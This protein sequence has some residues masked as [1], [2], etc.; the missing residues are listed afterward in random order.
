MSESTMATAGSTRGMNRKRI[1]LFAAT[2]MALLAIVVGP[3]LPA[4]AATQQ[5]KSYSC[6][7]NGSPNVSSCVSGKLAFPG[8]RV[9]VTAK[10]NVVSTMDIR[11]TGLGGRTCTSNK[12]AT[13][14]RLTCAAVP[15]GDGS[16][17]VIGGVR[18]NIS[19]T[20]SY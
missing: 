1:G 8:G 6:T 9:T 5:L 13:E 10:Q 2:A 3:T 14:F 12:V 20:V 4:Q 19:F 16:I 17:I 18:S 15:K 11:V 7:H